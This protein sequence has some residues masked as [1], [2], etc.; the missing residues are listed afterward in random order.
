MDWWTSVYA[1]Q[2]AAVNDSERLESFKTTAAS[3]AAQV[4]IISASLPG[5]TPTASGCR[6]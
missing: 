6:G 1:D 3:T 4:A 2:V 5:F